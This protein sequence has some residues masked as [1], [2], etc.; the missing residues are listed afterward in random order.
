M[1][2]KTIT[3]NGKAHTVSATAAAYINRYVAKREVAPAVSVRTANKAN[4]YKLLNT[5]PK[6]KSVDGQPIAKLYKR[7]SWGKHEAC[8]GSFG[9]HSVCSCECHSA[10][11]E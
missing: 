5:A 10:A 4:G 6:A 8:D 9:T 3:L 7:C 2:T 1:T 11:G